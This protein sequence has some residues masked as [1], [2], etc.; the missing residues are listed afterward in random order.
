M[1]LFS[2]DDNFYDAPETLS[3]KTS[4][5]SRP[6]PTS[7]SS[8]VTESRHFP[9]TN[10]NQNTEPESNHS[11]NNNNA[12]CSTNSSRAAIDPVSNDIIKRTVIAEGKKKKLQQ[13]RRP[14]GVQPP[15]YIYKEPSVKNEQSTMSGTGD[16]ST[17]HNDDTFQQQQQQ[18]QVAH[19]VKKSK[20][21][22][23]K[24][25]ILAKMDRLKIRGNKNYRHNT[26][27]IKKNKKQQ[28]IDHDEQEE[29][30]EIDT[31][32]SISSTSSSDVKYRHRSSLSRYPQ[33]LDCNTSRRVSLVTNNAPTPHGGR[34]VKLRSKARR[35]HGKDFGR[36]IEAQTL[37]VNQ[38]TNQ[39][40]ARVTK[41]H[42]NYCDHIRMRS[43]EIVS[44]TSLDQQ[45]RGG[46]YMDTE[47]G[48][49]GPGAIWSMKFS[50][51]G[52]YMAAGGQNC[53]IR[54]WKIKDCCYTRD[55][56]HNTLHPKHKQRQSVSNE[57]EEQQNNEFSGHSIHIFE[58]EPIR[59]FRGHTADILDLCWSKKNFLLSSSM[60][61]TVMLWNISV[62]NCLCVFKHVDFVTSVAFHPFDDRLFLSGSADGKVRLWSVPKKSV[63]QWNN[64]PDNNIITAVNFTADGKMICA[65]TYD[66]QIFLFDTN[67]MK[68]I[69][70]F[71]VKKEGSNK[72]GRKITG[73]QTVPGLPCDNDKILVTSNDSMVRLYSIRDQKIIFKY[74]GAENESTQI[75]ASFSDD[76]QLIVCGSDKGRIHIWSTDPHETLCM[77]KCNSR[78]EASLGQLITQFP[79]PMSNN[80]TVSDIVDS[81][82]HDPSNNNNSRRGMNDR[83]S[84]SSWVHRNVYRGGGG[85]GG[86][87]HH[88]HHHYPIPSTNYYFTGHQGIVTCAIFAPTKTRQQ[89]AATGE[90]IIYNYTPIPYVYR[91]TL[92]FDDKQNNDIDVNNIDTTELQDNNSNT[93][94]IFTVNNDNNTT[95]RTSY[96]MQSIPENDLQTLKARLEYP[97]SEG[98]IIVSA[99]EKGCIKVW[100]IDSGTYDNNDDHAS[101]SSSIYTKSNNQ[102]S[103]VSSISLSTLGGGKGQE[104][105]NNHS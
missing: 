63:L 72:R 24:G 32:S 92:H 43:K 54:V 22:A 9:E 50:Q 27:E 85:E 42:Y 79:E 7:T 60:D 77:N 53:V 15:M 6:S 47:N 16:R 59:I 2:S 14:E 38:Y 56:N 80:S 58:Q 49:P 46:P 90:D 88:D 70:Q 95:V 10:V 48:D 55:G 98:Q 68:Y 1:S 93:Q 39:N 67:D 81:S 4:Q 82:Q 33:L 69:S 76:G 34:Y 103:R 66:G 45:Q 37:N 74:K 31:E 87:Q 26:D 51:D 86:D 35:Q 52:Q 102:R 25:G 105:S 5:S 28:L 29:E 36:I 75:Q 104:S 62:Q 97:Y 100:R 101:S 78:S 99:N 18:Q 8:I 44:D 20:I 91:N 65:G 21:K 17:N 30:N 11:N 73:I 19:Q 13:Y 94:P 61:N 41:K 64:P 23:I 89:L 12:S 71:S 3:I 96:S 57:S 40:D 83:K 84:F